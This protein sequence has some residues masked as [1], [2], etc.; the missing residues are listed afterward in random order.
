MSEKD[1]VIKQ[2]KTF[3]MPVRWESYPIV[4]KPITGITQAAPCIV[5]CASHLVPDGWRVA[6][7]SVKGMKEI[8]AKN[9]PLQDTDYVQATVVD[10]DKLELNTVNSSEYAAYTSGGYIRYNTP[11]DI[12]GMKARMSIKDKVGGTLLM[13]LTTENNRI[14]IDAVNKIILL[15]I[16]A[17]DTALITWKKGV[18]D[19]ELVSADTVEV[20]EILKGAVSV[21]K[22]STT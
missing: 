20:V 1:I 19:L 13:S 16:S 5:T 11:V 4:Y 21:E 12:T 3:S 9:S 22:E 7:V 8:N 14:S 6:V 15:H 18:Y 10:P 2:G 17:A